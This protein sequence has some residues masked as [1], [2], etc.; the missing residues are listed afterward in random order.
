MPTRKKQYISADD[1]YRFKLITDCQISPSGKHVVFCV[2]RVDRKTKKKYSNL[3]IVPTERGRAWQFTYGNQVDS[4]PKW[5]PDGKY[6]AF[7]SNRDD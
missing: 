6:I 4:Q 5:S 1:L 2:Q 7:I 3:W